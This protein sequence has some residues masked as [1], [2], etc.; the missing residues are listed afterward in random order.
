MNVLLFVALL[1]PCQSGGK[2]VKNSDVLVS[3][4]WSDRSRVIS[5]TPSE[6]WTDGVAWILA[7]RDREHACWK[8]VYTFLRPSNDSEDLIYLRIG[9]T[10]RYDYTTNDDF[11]MTWKMNP[12]FK[13]QGMLL[14]IPLESSSVP[15]EI[16]T[17]SIT[18]VFYVDES[19]K[20]TTRRAEPE[21]F[22]QSLAGTGD[23]IT[24]RDP[25]TVRIGETLRLRGGNNGLQTINFPDLLPPGFRNRQD[26]Q[27][28][29][30]NFRPDG[31]SSI[32]KLWTQAKQSGNPKEVLEISNILLKL[33]SNRAELHHFRG[34][35]Y[36]QLNE[37]QN[38][39]D[40]YSRAVELNSR[41]GSLLRSRAIE[42]S[43]LKK[44]SHAK[45]DCISALQL[46]PNNSYCLNQ[47]AWLLATC[48]D[49][50]VRDGTLAVKYADK[51]CQQTMFKDWTYVDTLA[52][53]YAEARD[54]RRA[55]YWQTEALELLTE[56]KSREGLTERLAL[57]KAEKAYV[58]P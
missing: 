47:L 27:K 54:F 12:K 38:A 13:P 43:K 5:L 41:S 26:K 51:V 1:L 3:Q 21:G 6:K 18:S 44:Y 8:G 24:L 30:T 45:A 22:L 28:V 31:N 58:E 57:Y 35:A 17:A 42:Y 19:G 53:A 32:E 14:E 33:D 56:E 37:H 7:T 29:V 48:P 36:A 52:A 4:D 55:V 2:I 16:L 10:R 23:V 20:E 15:Q 11:E 9:L 39:V 49:A 34:W 46:E 40:S 25:E 50:T